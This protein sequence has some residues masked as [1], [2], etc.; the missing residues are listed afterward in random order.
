MDSGIHCNHVHFR[1]H[2]KLVLPPPLR[3][4]DF[5]A[6]TY[7]SL[8]AGQELAPDLS[9]QEALVDWHGRGTH[10]ASIICGESRQDYDYVGIAP[11][12]KVLSLKIYLRY[13]LKAAQRQSS[14]SW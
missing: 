2:G 13:S 7:E 4:A 14:T 5:S 11:K 12:C 1:K 3:H 9:E 6:L 8:D 10:A